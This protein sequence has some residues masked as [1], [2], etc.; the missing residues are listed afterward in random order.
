MPWKE[1][2][3]MDRLEQNSASVT[4][5]RADHKRLPPSTSALAAISN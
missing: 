2:H 1:C 5:Y 4:E 3:V